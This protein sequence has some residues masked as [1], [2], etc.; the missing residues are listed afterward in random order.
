MIFF[1]FPYNKQMDTEGL[2]TN[3]KQI[4]KENHTSGIFHTHVSLITPKGKFQFNRTTLEN[5]WNIYC[6]YISTTEDPIIGIAEKPQQLVPVLVD[7][8]I[9][10][11]DSGEYTVEDSLYTE[12]QLKAVVTAYQSTLRN[13]LDECK[14]SDLNCVVLE[15]SLSQEVKGELSYFKQGFHL[16]FPIFVDK[17]DQE[18][19]IIPRAQQ[20]LKEQQIFQNL[21]IDDSGN[22]IDKSCCKV[23]WLL[24]SSRKSEDKQ[25][26]IITKIYNSNLEEISLEQ[27]FSNY[28]IYNDK[29]QPIPL[30]NKIEFY[31]PRILSILPY[32]RPGKSLK[33]GLISPLKQKIK[34]E[35][36]ISAVQKRISTP[37]SI[38][39]CKKLLPMLADFR[40]AEHNEWI[41]IGWLL[42]NVTDGDQEG[43]DLWCNFSSRCEDKYDENECIH[44]WDGMVRKDLGIGTLKY[45]ASI[46]NPELYSK[47]KEEQSEKFLISSLEGSHNDVAKAL[48][49]EYADE[50]VCASVTSHIWYQFIN[51]TWEPIEDGV[52][53]R[54]KISGKIVDRYVN[55]IKT[56]YDKLRDAEDKGKA[57]IVQNQI[58]Q[59]NKMISN[60]KN[61]NYKNC[62]MKECAEVFYDQKFKERLDMD[63]YLI[64]F[65]NGVYDLKNNVFRA[66]RPE[67]YLSKKMPINYIVYNMDDEKVH[68]VLTFLEQV[69]PDK[70]VRK[71]FMD[72]S[73]DIF[74]GGNHE[75]IVV[76]WTGDG[77]NG[78][79]VTQMFFEKMLG[80]L[81][82]KMNTNVITGKKPNSGSAFADLVRAGGGVRLAVLEEPD[83]D[84][85]INPGIF[86]HLSGNDSFYA[87]DLFEKG[88]D[89]REIT[90]LMKIFLVCNKLPRIK[91]ADK[92]V[93]NRTRVLPFESTFCRP[94]DQNPAPESYEEQLNQKRF[95]MDKQFSKKIPQ[96][97]E[98]FAWLLLEHRKKIAGQGRIEPD[99]VRAATE[100]YQRQNDIYRQF[101]EECIMEDPKKSLNLI[102]VYTLFKNWFKESL[103]GQSLPVKNEVEEYL[104]K[105]WGSPDIG[106]SWKGYTERTIQDRMEKGDAFVF[107]DEEM[108]SSGLPPM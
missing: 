103:P 10:I 91:N 105:V 59:I 12:Q 76:F 104:V 99:K 106:K 30:K 108:K 43:L 94:N 65:R 68:E 16:H 51:H 31:L 3:L 19:H 53:L 100:F 58:K 87:R 4:L 96:L 21:G 57:G 20:I 93:W 98:A 66:G 86:K 77:D 46:D 64:A 17:N 73:S 44:K 72:I 95:P 82:I 97:V 88:K 18:M 36:K 28:I 38:E 23:P 14:D 35:R 45:F 80:K 54:E 61:S 40:A 83:S 74:L 92:A 67:D 102:A 6:N 78:K 13:V 9:K 8:D 7:V 84:E 25:P 63:P 49:E 71:Y 24:Y 60:L 107:T 37:E 101:L 1:Y 55:A 2:H 81:T 69:F 5:F 11:R 15:K 22:V 48:F 47:F 89:V 27:A 39:L 41:T 33:H 29:E 90:P 62:V 34:K 26:Y 75:K 85:V 42:F 50:F 79:S 70:S 52:F 32:N 56:L